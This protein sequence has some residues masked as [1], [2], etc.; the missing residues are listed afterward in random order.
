MKTALLIAA[1]ALAGGVQDSVPASADS[2]EALINALHPPPKLKEPPTA[3]ALPSGY[4]HASSVDFEGNL[5]GK[6]TKSGGLLIE[7]SVFGGLY[8]TEYPVDKSQY[9]EYVEEVIRGR[10]LWRGFRSG[11]YEVKFEQC[12][13][14]KSSYVV[15]FSAAVKESSEAVAMVTIARSVAKRESG[16]NCDMSFPDRLRGYDHDLSID[17]SGQGR[18]VGK[19]TR[20]GLSI[21][22]KMPLVPYQR[23]V[24]IDKAEYREFA[25]EMSNGHHLWRGF[26][27]E[28]YEVNV[29]VCRVPE[30]SRIVRFTTQVQES[31]QAADMLVIA[32]SL[33]APDRQRID[34]CVSID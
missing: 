4:R 10:L 18:Y 27:N 19:M 7:Y 24:P 15:H 32:R 8:T 30:V 5:S 21:E 28:Q 11:R 23:R 1:L 16:I 17:E 14:P 26:Q 13:T 2:R 22:Y 29:D 9:R 34:G 3:M 6:I 20:P 25:E 12:R 31:S 33:V